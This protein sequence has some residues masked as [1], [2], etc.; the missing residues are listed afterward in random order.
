MIIVFNICLIK[1]G[2]ESFSNGDRDLHLTEHG[3]V[4]NDVLDRFLFNCHFHQALC[5]GII[6]VSTLK[7]KEHKC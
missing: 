2:N 1:M 5:Y 7:T 6:Y 4:K 3:N